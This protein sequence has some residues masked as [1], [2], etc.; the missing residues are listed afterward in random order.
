MSTNAPS[1]YPRD[2]DAR[3]LFEVKGESV[4]E[5]TGNTSCNHLPIG[6]PRGSSSWRLNDE[7]EMLMQKQVWSP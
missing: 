6:T 2:A 4:Q 7:N 1:L 5:T 3:A